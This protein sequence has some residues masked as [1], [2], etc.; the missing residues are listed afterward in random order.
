VSSI[1][2]DTEGLIVVD[3]A[4]GKLQSRITDSFT[5]GDNVLVVIR[6]ECIAVGMN[7]AEGA[8]I[9][10]G[11]VDTLSFLGNLVDCSINVEGQALQVQLSPPATVQSGQQVTL[12][13]PP[14]N[15]VAM[16][17]A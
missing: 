7:G 5:S 6:P 9:V 15:C 1:E 12:H 10:E 13:L 3:T 14:D 2:R 11:T 17:D 16:R 8:N 4:V